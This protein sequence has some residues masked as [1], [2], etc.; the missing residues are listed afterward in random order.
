M[1]SDSLSPSTQATLQVGVKILLQNSEGKYLLVRRNVE[2]Y[3]DAGA[4]W[5]IVGGRIHPGSLLFENLKR[6][7]KEETG[8]MLTTE[9]KL[10]AAQ[11]ILKV[12]GKHIVRLTYVGTIEDFETNKNSRSIENEITLDDEND[13]YGWFT[14]EEIKLIENLDPYLREVIK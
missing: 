3:P 8:L 7:V 5:D 13:E 1:Q 2:K 11:D 4:I 10:I 9:P 12:P 14:L 6:E